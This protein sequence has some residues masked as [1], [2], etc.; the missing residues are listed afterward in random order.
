MTYLEKIN[1]GDE[2]MH[3]ATEIASRYGILSE[4]RKPHTK[5]IAKWLSTRRQHQ[6]YH[7]TAVPRY[8]AVCSAEL[9]VCR[10]C[11]AFVDEGEQHA[12][13]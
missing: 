6:L 5:M 7:N 13:D 8:C 9:G 11:G 1:P 10:R 2:M 4:A 12:K 3:N